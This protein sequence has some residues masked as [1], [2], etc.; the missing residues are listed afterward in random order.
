MK[1]VEIELKSGDILTI[2]MTQKL[3]DCIKN[4]FCLS[5]EEEITESHITNYLISSMKNTLEL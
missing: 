4:A 1:S 3:V 5:C 2:D